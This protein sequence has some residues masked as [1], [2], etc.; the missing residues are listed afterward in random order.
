M[1]RPFGGCCSCGKPT[2]SHKVGGRLVCH[3]CHTN[4]QP[5]LVTDGGWEA[6]KEEQR[7]DDGAP[8]DEISQRLQEALDEGRF[9]GDG[10]EPAELELY[11]DLLMAGAP[12]EYNEP[13]LFKCAKGGKDPYLR[14]GSWKDESNRLTP[15]EAIKAMEHG[16]NI[17]LAGME[18]DRLSQKDIDELE[19][20]DL[21]NL[22]SG[23]TVRSQSRTGF[24]QPE[25]SEEPGAIPNIPHAEA[26]EIRAQ[27]QYTI[28]PGSHIDPDDED[29]YQ[30]EVVF[31]APDTQE[32]LV[33]YYTVEMAGEPN[34][35]EYDDLPEVFRRYQEQ[36]KREET[37]GT[38]TEQ[39]RDGDTGER[40]GREIYETTDDT[41]HDSNGNRSAIFDLRAEQ[42]V[43]TE[44]EST[45][46]TERWSA[47]FHGSTTDAN[48]SI[49]E[50]GI[51]QCWRHSHSHGTLQILA[52]LC[53]ET[54]SGDSGCPKI[55][56]AHSGV[57]GGGCTLNTGELNWRA[58]KY[59]KKQEHVPSDDPI[60]RTA[61]IHLALHHDICDA[62]DVEDG[63]KIPETDYAE[64]L[65]LVEDEYGLNPGRDAHTGGSR[66]G[67]RSLNQGAILPD[68]TPTDT[69]P[70]ITQQD[71]WDLTY[72]AIDNAME[73]EREV[74]VDAIMSGGKTYNSLKAAYDRDER[75]AFFTSRSDLYDQVKET[76][77]EIG[78]DESEIFILPSINR[79]C[80][81]Y[82][83]EHGER[84]QK[85]LEK[86]KT[87]GLNGG[88]I[89]TH[90]DGIPC[91]GGHDDDEKCHYEIRWDLYDPEQH[92]LVIGNY[93][94]A[95]LPH[96]TKDRHAVFD[97]D[98]GSAFTDRIEGEVLIRAINAF[99]DMDGSPPID[100]FNELLEIRHDE[101]AKRRA[102]GWF[103]N[104][105]FE[106]ETSKAANSYEQGFHALAPH[107]V[108]AI[109]KAQPI[110]DGS[111]FEHAY[112]PGVDNHAL[113][114]T[115]DDQKGE[116]Y[117]EL[118][119]TP[120]PNYTNAVIALDGTPLVID[121]DK[122]HSK[123]PEWS[124]ELGVKLDHEKILNNSER[125]DFIRNT[126]NIKFVV[127]SDA[128]KPYSSG[129]YA[130]PAED[131]ALCHAVK[132]KYGDGTA[133]VAVTSKTVC[134]RYEAEGF[135]E[136]GV[137]S[138]FEYPGNLR[139]T[140]RHSDTRLAI[141]I[142]S[143]HHGDHE[144]ARRAAWL[145][146]SIDPEG[147][148]KN[149]DYGSEI[150]NKIL[151]NMREQQTFQNILRFGRDGGGATV[152]MHTSAYPDLLH[153]EGYGSIEPWSEGMRELVDA[154]KD[155]P[156][157]GVTSSDVAEHPAV[158]KS[159]RRVRSLLEKAAT[160][161]GL[162]TRHEGEGTNGAHLYADAGMGALEEEEMAEMEIPDLDDETMD[163]ETMEDLGLVDDDGEPLVEAVEISRYSLN[164]SNLR[165]AEGEPGESSGD[166][167]VATDGGVDAGGDGP[168]RA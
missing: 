53:D 160:D 133:P 42:I 29:E 83:C 108:Y 124:K 152:V 154:W 145:R 16:F 105:E 163:D 167:G 56:K 62:G 65:E 155:L 102:E 54:E 57:A 47:M 77:I 73:Q 85:T 139:G 31:E 68:I 117:I 103:N 87:L 123:V 15:E 67:E 142:G 110:N 98:P 136:D 149:R 24:H 143:T 156:D 39:H 63:W 125:A 78:F 34:R 148:G 121:S 164:T 100:D 19:H 166:D 28:A 13:W 51:L 99:L 61:L 50:E 112:M 116:F 21:T 8:N 36:K 161:H 1:G 91:K 97:E 113:F 114:F 122:F 137:V 134:D 59:A 130:N 104:H 118:R 75:T 30:Q 64:A 18:D 144:I 37:T 140:N 96:V 49:S 94:H 138:E 71:H 60:P 135:I 111:N 157:S 26:G 70:G 165:S 44:G 76:A 115:T 92:K 66:S 14:Q 147:R 4:H 95:H 5:R 38:G 79:D 82:N 20:F 84:W 132:E 11:L 131:K 41:E 32:P 23:L 33:G 69:D 80:P 43:Q 46:P 45:D 107:A 12:D 168:P 35:I 52:T 119:D 101:M 106:P 55:G 126:L 72:D 81:T 146:G 162:L 6:D 89:H 22:N 74:L 128:T 17:G 25:F 9:D 150:G 27:G 10:P 109:L 7:A 127:T 158:S 88:D 93:Q 48:M 40:D 3:D 153:I 86:Q 151:E 90:N 120:N 129:N 159:D 2:R 58:W 141:Q